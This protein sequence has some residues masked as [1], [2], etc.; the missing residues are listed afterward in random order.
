M[1]NI[2]T[3][4][5]SVFPDVP[6]GGTIIVQDLYSSYRPRD[7]EFILLVERAEPQ[8]HQGLYVVNIGDVERLTDEWNGW[9]CC[10]PDGIRHDLVLT[11]LEPRFDG[12]RLIAL[13]YAD[14]EQFIGVDQTLSLEAALL[15]STRLG[16]PT[17]ESVADVLFYLYER[18]GLLL[19]SHSYTDLPTTPTIPF[20]AERLDR[21][22]R[23]NLEACANPRGPVFDT[24]AVAISASFDAGLSDRFLDPYRFALAVLNDPGDCVPRLLRG[25]GHGDLHGRNV[26]VGR[27]GDR[28]LWPAVFD[29]GD[30][31]MDNLIGWDF[32]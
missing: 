16:V 26:L 27:V 24:R 17:A 12:K 31:G 14:A 19:Y 21:R 15:E 20:T 8:T 6:S 5:Q 4:L 10:R 29:Y 13:V 2:E 7:G 22:I 32:V 1:Q 25:Y 3:I 18:L 9:N 30:M 23:A 28:V 11:T